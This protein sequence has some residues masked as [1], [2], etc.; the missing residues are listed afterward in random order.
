MSYFFL[1]TSALVKRYM[2]EPGSGWVLDL[3]D[4]QQEH[5]MVLAEITIVENAV[6]YCAIAEWDAEWM[7]VAICSTSARVSS[8]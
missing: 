8:G 6:P 7:Q 4:S 1:D 3:T 2:Q 5:S